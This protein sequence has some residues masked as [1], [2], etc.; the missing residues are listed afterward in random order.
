[1]NVLN[2]LLVFNHLKDLKALNPAKLLFI[3]YFFAVVK[4]FV[5]SSDVTVDVTLG[6]K[7][8][9]KCPP[10]GKGFGVSYDWG[11]FSSLDGFK[12][13]GTTENRFITSQGDLIFSYIT[14]QDIDDVSNIGGLQCRMQAGKNYYDSHTIRLNKVGS[15]MYGKR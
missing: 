15:G 7:K 13:L 4:E 12:S 3:K 6:R 9:I 5:G 10:R 8:V 1:M 2:V 14:Q 11:K